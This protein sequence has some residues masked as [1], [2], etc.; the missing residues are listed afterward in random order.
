MG[1]GIEPRLALAGVA[2]RPVAREHLVNS[3]I[4]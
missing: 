2:L 1:A 4:W 3:S